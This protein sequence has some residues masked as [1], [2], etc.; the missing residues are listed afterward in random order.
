MLLLLLLLHCVCFCLLQSL[1]HFRINRRQNLLLHLCLVLL[2][3]FQLVR[4]LVMG[5][6]VAG[7]W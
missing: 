4:E 7:W 1:V 3:T 2:Q 5:C 6:G